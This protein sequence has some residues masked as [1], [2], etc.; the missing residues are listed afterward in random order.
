MSNKLISGA[1]GVEVKL[2]TGVPRIYLPD[3]IDLRKKRIKHIDFFTA[4]QIAKAPS[5]SD[6]T[7]AGV[8]TS[9]FITL[10]ESN[11]Q[12]ELIMSLSVVELNTAGNR[13]FINKIIDLQRSF[14]DVTGVTNPAHLTNKSVYLV[15]WYDEPAIWGI[16]NDND[17]TAIQSFEITLTGLKTYFAENR[18]LLNKRYQNILLSYPDKT[19]T[20]NEGITSNHISNKFITLQR[21]GVQFI[22]QVPLYLFYQSGLNFPLR[23]QNIQFDMQNSYIETLGVTADD[24]KTVFFNAIID[25]NPS[26]KH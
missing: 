9:L 21:H 22:S 1:I 25:D 14:I 6:L 3:V 5:G 24:L 19:P 12:K 16:V 10:V 7:V 15:F 8:E 18:D 4:L 23:L 11:T 2:Q 17:R 20:G 26:S 13:L